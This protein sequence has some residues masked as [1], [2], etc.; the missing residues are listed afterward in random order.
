MTDITTKK[1]FRIDLNPK[2]LFLFPV[3]LSRH[4]HHPIAPCQRDRDMA[5][6]HQRAVMIHASLFLGR[7]P[8][9]NICDRIASH[10]RSLI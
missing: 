3:I 8:S 4:K 6:F 9:G 7:G 10:S 1:S 2:T 5:G